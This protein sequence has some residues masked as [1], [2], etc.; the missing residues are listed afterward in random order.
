MLLRVHQD[1]HIIIHGQKTTPFDLQL[2]NRLEHSRQPVVQTFIGHHR[3]SFQFVETPFGIFD[4]IDQAIPDVV[5]QQDSAV[6]TS[7]ETIELFK[8][9]AITPWFPNDITHIGTVGIGY[10]NHTTR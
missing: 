6:N 2:V 9:S 4:V 3:G 5:Q 10:L 7:G 1:P 8:V